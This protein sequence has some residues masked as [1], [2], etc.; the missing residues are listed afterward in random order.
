[1]PNEISAEVREADAQWAVDLATADIIRLINADYPAPNSIRG[2]L[3]TEA[4]RLRRLAALSRGVAELEHALA[5]YDA[6]TGRF[7]KQKRPSRVIA[8]A[9]KLVGGGA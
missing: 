9:R 1:M 4:E 3:S 6:A 5:E 8:A 2:W 7:P